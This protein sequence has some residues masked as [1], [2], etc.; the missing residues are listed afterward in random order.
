MAQHL[1][2]TNVISYPEQVAMLVEKGFCLWNILATCA[3]K[4]SLDSAIA[5]EQRPNDV[6]GFCQAH[7][8]V[9]RIVL[10]SAGSCSKL[11]RRHNQEWWDSGQLVLYNN[12]D[13]DGVEEEDDSYSTGGTTVAD[14][15]QAMAHVF[16][17][18]GVP[19][20]DCTAVYGYSMN[21]VTAMAALP[22]GGHFLILWNS[23][24]GRS[25][26]KEN[27]DSDRIVTCYPHRGSACTHSR[28]PWTYLEQYLDAS[29]Y[30][31]GSNNDS[32]DSNG[33]LGPPASRYWTPLHEIQALWQVNAGSVVA[34]VAQAS[35]LLHDNR[36]SGINRHVV[37]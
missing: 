35:T 11:F 33:G 8:S 36:Q 18:L 17:S 16:D 23:N 10:S 37:R 21:D 31:D 32:G 9:R 15:I 5:P 34:G 12:D 28:R 24:T 29:L 20:Y 1:R 22:Q 14:M 30:G 2:L 27:W 26:A 4:G 6:F 25:C 7:P 13:D 3:R 19:Y